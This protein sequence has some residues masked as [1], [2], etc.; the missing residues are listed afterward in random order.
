MNF[1]NLTYLAQVTKCRPILGIKDSKVAQLN[2]PVGPSFRFW[3]AGPTDQ[4]STD[5]N[6]TNQMLQVG[7]QD[8]SRM[9]GSGSLL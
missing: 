6:D 5:T 8:R 9:Q 1:G 7:G 4:N 2:Q 3:Q